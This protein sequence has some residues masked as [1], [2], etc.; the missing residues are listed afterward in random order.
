MFEGVH[1]GGVCLRVCMFKG[2]HG[3][4]VCLRVCMVEVYV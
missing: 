2:V 1:G 3:G 4:G